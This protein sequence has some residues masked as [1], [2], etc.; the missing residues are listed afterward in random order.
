MIYNGHYY[1]KEVKE[2][3]RWYDPETDEVKGDANVAVI[4]GNRR[5]GKTV[6]VG[7]DILVRN[8]LERGERCV[9]LARIK[10]QVKR[11]Y[12]PRWWQKVLCNDD[13]GITKELLKHELKY[14]TTV[15]PK[16]LLTVDGDPFCYC[17]PI[18]GSTSVKDEYMF[19]KATTILLDEA[20]QDR[21]RQLVIE[22]RPALSRIWEIHLTVA[23]SW[24]HA[25]A[26]T[27]LIFVANSS[28]RENWVFSDLGVNN[29]VRSD[30]KFTC[31]K[32]ICFEM[33]LNKVVAEEF[34]KS[35]IAQIMRNSVTGADYIEAA[36]HNAFDDN[37]AFVKPKSLDFKKLAVQ[38]MLRGFDLGVFMDEHGAH[39]AKIDPDDRSRKI[40]NTQKAHK[41]D[42]TYE[43]F[44]EWE[45]RLCDLY[46]RG[47]L[48][49]QSQES[50][51]LF[52]EYCHMSK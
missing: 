21:E 31:Q 25:T 48:T 27:N 34:D 49:F 23:R 17:V 12:L 52:L 1:P 38:L 19:D 4:C 9:L 3:L 29:F 2:H 28:Q 47:K 32:G 50:K 15:F 51:G 7:L 8:Y 11:G 13:F 16:D 45:R 41:E 35:L 26:C 18:S 44:G 6:G 46:K 43:F 10:D 24:E 5:G 40:C 42:V 30:T 33:V 37:T 36:V 22:G 39:I 14:E 20:F